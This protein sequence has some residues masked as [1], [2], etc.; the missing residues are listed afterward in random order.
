MLSR[1]GLGSLS[2]SSRKHG[3]LERSVSDGSGL[4]TQST[5]DP[6]AKHLCLLLDHEYDLSLVPELRDLGIFVCKSQ[7]AMCGRVLGVELEE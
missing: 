3:D 1:L 5:L 6:L 2:Q 7:G 4:E